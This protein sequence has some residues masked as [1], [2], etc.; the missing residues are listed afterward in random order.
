[1]TIWLFCILP[2]R[3]FTNKRQWYLGRE[4]YRNIFDSIDS[5]IFREGLNGNYS[6]FCGSIKLNSQSFTIHDFLSCRSVALYNLDLYLPMKP[7]WDFL[8]IC[9]CFLLE[10]LICLCALCALCSLFMWNCDG[11]AIVGREVKESN[12]NQ[13]KWLFHINYNVFSFIEMRR[14]SK[15]KDASKWEN[16]LWM[17]MDN[18][19]AEVVKGEQ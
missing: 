14:K 18:D 13:W 5:M 17:V 10:Y 11:S 15:N 12:P 1:M 16:F 7:L 6:K 9:N 3:K 8:S 4:I 19:I 2:I